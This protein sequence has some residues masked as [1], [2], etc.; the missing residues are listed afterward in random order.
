MRSIQVTIAIRNCS[1]VRQVR[2]F[3][4]LF[5]S[6]PKGRLCRCP[7]AATSDIRRHGGRCVQ[8]VRCASCRR[9]GTRRGR[10]HAGPSGTRPARWSA[11]CPRCRGRASSG[12][13]MNSP[14]AAATAIGRPVGSPSVR[15]RRG[16]DASDKLVGLLSTTLLPLRAGGKPPMQLSGVDRLTSGD[17]SLGLADLL[18][19]ARRGQGE[20]RRS[21]HL[22]L[23]VR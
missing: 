10:R 5:C 20:L 13:V 2:R 22:P 8:R 14:T 17:V 7:R 6:R 18:Q 21:K 4:T 12:P 23:R 19:R 15:A 11:A 3:R 9:C 16:A 1:R